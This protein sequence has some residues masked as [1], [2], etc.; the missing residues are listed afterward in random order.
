[1]NIEILLFYIFSSIAL[2]SSVMVISA[3]NPIHSILFLIL[4]FCNAA[5][6]LILL[7]VEFLAMLFLIVYVGAISVLF[8]FVIMMLNVKLTEFN[9]S[10]LRYLPIGGV[11][12]FIF[13]I[14]V[15]SIIDADL[16]PLF[17]NQSFSNI[18]YLLHD[19]NSVAWINNVDFITN[20]QVLG[21]LIYTYYFVLFLI[22]GMLLLVSMIG[23]IILTLN[24]RTNARKQNI[25]QQLNSVTPD[26][27]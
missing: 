24:K 27:Q 20:S 6:L 9:Q 26:Y 2:M 13:L 3:R 25:L 15:L 4:V 17:G 14:E 21:N 23:A 22:A 1:M 11:I 12:V 8:L 10:V 18:K 16:V 7:E 5:G 19:L